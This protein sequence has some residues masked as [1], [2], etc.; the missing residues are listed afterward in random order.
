MFITLNIYLDLVDIDLVIIKLVW[1]FGESVVAVVGMTLRVRRVGY[2]MV[3]WNCSGAWIL[4][5]GWRCINGRINY[6][7]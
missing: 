3:L 6:G 7:Y 5:K 4:G 1:V 2:L